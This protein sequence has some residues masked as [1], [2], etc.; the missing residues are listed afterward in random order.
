MTRKRA[1]RLCG[2][3]AAAAAV[4]TAAVLP[5][6]A[7][8]PLG[9]SKHALSVVTA[10]G[11][12]SKY[13]EFYKGGKQQS[14]SALT[15][16]DDPVR[17]KVLSLSGENEY[18][19][20]VSDPLPL[21]KSTFTTWVNW[22]Q[23]GEDEPVL[24]SMSSRITDD[25]L[26]LSLRHRDDGRGIDGVYLRFYHVDD[27]LIEWYNPVSDGVSY[28][29]PENEWHHLAL[30]VDGRYF[31]LYVD[32]RLWFEKMLIMGLVEMR[33]NRLY[34]GTTGEENAPTLKAKLADVRLYDSA[35]SAAQVARAMETGPNPFDSSQTATAASTTLYHPTAP[36]TTAA[37][38][39]PTK[40]AEGPIVIGGFPLT[41]L[42]IMGGIVVVFI[43]L[44]V[45]LSRRGK[46][47]DRQ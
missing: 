1:A 14:S 42:L 30:T 17:G 16:V 3:L 32:G 34:F 45:I 41:T 15:W 12:S 38:A 13:V 9:Y 10:P 2:I 31:R 20:V 46:R 18:V 28:A 33:A 26:T 24:F 5:V 27:T 40:A 7:A 37:T 8:M 22:T 6:S 44:S 23:Q 47:G 19:Q 39:A 11:K 36:A 4:L 21:M 29:I 25:R 43:L 35:M